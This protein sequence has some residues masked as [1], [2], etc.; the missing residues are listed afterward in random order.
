MPLPF[1]RGRPTALLTSYALLA[2]VA[3]P[4]SST[5]AA[6]AAATTTPTTTAGSCPPTSTGTRS[7]PSPG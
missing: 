2:A 7:S 6:T 4:L 5:A 3:L 1:H